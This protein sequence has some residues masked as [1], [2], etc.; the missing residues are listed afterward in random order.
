M[1]FR[2]SNKVGNGGLSLRKVKSC[3]DVTVKY[4]DI[5]KIYNNHPNMSIFNEDGFWSHEPKEFNY[6]TTDEA[7]KFSFD[8][9]PSLCYKLNK[10][11]LPFGCHGWSKWKWINFWK[12]YIP[13]I[14]D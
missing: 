6:P 12:K 9:Y 5:I 10:N 13:K 3:L 8:K 7:L 11:T 2:S 14:N 4:D 1:L